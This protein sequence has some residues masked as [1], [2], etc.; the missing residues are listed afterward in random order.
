MG[1]TSCDRFGL[2]HRELAV[3]SKIVAGSTNRII[4]GDLAISG[5]TVQRHITAICAK[6]GVSNRLELTLFAIFHQLIEPPVISR[7]IA[8][9][10]TGAEKNGS[11]H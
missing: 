3:V 5:K 11:Q 7:R 6:L 8:H 10:R 2:T 1:E 9:A 4:A